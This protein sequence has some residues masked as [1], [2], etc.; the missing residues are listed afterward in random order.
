MKW[1]LFRSDTRF[2]N[3]DG[4][5]FSTVIIDTG[6]NRASSFFGPDANRDGIAD[7]IVYQYDFADNDANAAD[8]HG[9]GSNVASAAA[10][11]NS[12]NPG[13]APGANIIALKVFKNS[14]SGNFSYT[15]KAL[16]WVITNAAR[17]NIASVNLSLGDGNNF[18]GRQSMYGLGDEF[19]RLAQMGVVVV[20]A[21]GNSFYSFNG[22]Q[23]LA[24][25]AADPNV[26]SVGAVYSSNI[27]GVG[28]GGGA[29]ASTTAPDRIAPFSQRSSTLDI[30]APG[31]AVVGAA[32]S[33]SGTTSMHGTS[34]AAPQI[35][36]AALL[37]QQLAM[38]TLGRKLTVG[39]F[40]YVLTTSA[41]SIVDGDD[42]NDNAANTGRTFKR[43]DILAMGNAIINLARVVT[44]RAPTLTSVAT[45]T[46]FVA[47]RASTITYQ[48]LA[49]A[50]NEF[51]P[52]GDAV[53]FR[54]DSIAGGGTLRRNGVVIGTTT[55]VSPGD[56]LTYTPSANANG[57]FN[58][59]AVRASDGRAVSA[60]SV[61]VPVNVG[62]T[63]SGVI[64]I[65]SSS[66]SPS[67]VSDTTI[68][69]AITG[70]PA[71]PAWLNAQPSNSLA[72][73][74]ESGFANRLAHAFEPSNAG[75]TAFFV[76]ASR[77]L[78]A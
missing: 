17:Y 54:I 45:L 72:F 1:N 32:G 14:G 10:S 74:A 16:Q 49:N 77:L 65:R 76:T 28:Y 20:A 21:A 50:A 68:A 67:A 22:Q 63:G 31:A 3:I 2:S 6:I 24:Y 9:H 58:A 75:S 38:Q 71:A 56:T 13:V 70:Q 33:G 66:S 44:N 64:S 36:G 60:S 4:R 73:A 7:R 48:M 42:E 47:G 19:S 15:E 40:R 41:A 55:L 46:G 78:A 23:G 57:R 27:G 11:S 37:A 59:F 12:T 53:K 51:D 52:D 26:I 8:A 25:P 35:A 5:G 29:I 43:A 39:E 61:P 62:R 34:Q 18:A 69:L 30:M